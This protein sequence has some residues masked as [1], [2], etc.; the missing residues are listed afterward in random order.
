MVFEPQCSEIMIKTTVFEA[1]CSEIMI[2][3]TVFVPGV[4]GVPRRQPNDATPIL[5][6]KPEIQGNYYR[7]QV[8][9]PTLAEA[10]VWG[11]HMFIHIYIHIYIYIC[12]YAHCLEG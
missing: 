10:L 12:I 5:S 3:T 9:A 8:R 6:R 2:K 4:P 1:Q 7:E 11:I